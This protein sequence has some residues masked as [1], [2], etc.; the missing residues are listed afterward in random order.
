M[1]IPNQTKIDRE[2]D[3]EIALAAD[4]ATRSLEWK[5]RPTRLELSFNNLCNLKCVMCAKSDDEPN[6]LLDKE[7]GI[8]FLDDVLPWVLHWTPSANS[9]PLLNDVDLLVELAQKHTA[10][11]HLITNGTLLTRARYE[12]VRERLHKLWISIDAA[13]KET[14]ETIRVP[15][16]WDVVMKNIRDVLPLA[17]EDGVEVT[18]NFVLMANNWR[19]AA[20]YVALVADLGGKAANIQ[21]LLPNS[22]QYPDLV[23]EDKFDAAA[24]AEVLERAKEVA[25]ER[26][27]DLKLELRPPFQGFFGH[28]P[29][30]EAFKAPLAE[31]R[32]RHGE[33]IAR[34][35]PSFC[36][37]ATT[38]LKVNPEGGVYPCCR[39]PEEL[40]MGDARTQ[41]FEEIWNGKAYQEFRRRMF[42]RDYPDVC[43]NCYV[44]VGNPAYQRMLADE[45][46][47]AGEDGEN[48]EAPRG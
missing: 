42:E 5:S 14:F 1:P 8:R 4:L 10:W 24:I 38:Y 39:G 34:A 25:A 21:E 11:M 48:G 7:V 32:M 15:A 44:L 33:A 16:K 28:N 30:T 18:F 41:T 36:S 27:I 40:R 43:K 2:L 6:W 3:N 13:T 22:S 9:E 29:P 35:H 37:M 47:E 17:L 46:A 31:L 23:W 19:E 12:K 26:K 45:R 20:D